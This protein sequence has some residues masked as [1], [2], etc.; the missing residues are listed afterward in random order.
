M[1][2]PPHPI[3]RASPVE[4]ANFYTVWR[5]NRDFYLYLPTFSN[6]LS[7]RLSI[8]FKYY[9]FI[10]Y[11]FFLITTHLPTFFLFNTLIII[12]EKNIWRMNSS[13]SNLMSYRS[14]G[15]K[16]N[17][18]LREAVGAWTVENWVLY[19]LYFAYPSSVGDALRTPQF[20]LTMM[21]FD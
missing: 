7:N 18:S 16:K 19:S 1:L 17:L 20:N 10:H 3:L 21:D 8:S 15:K 11:L 6:T 4:S 12:I 9:F 2:L 14:L 5:M 13:S